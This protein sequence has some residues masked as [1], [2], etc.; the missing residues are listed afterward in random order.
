MN[1]L[2][3]SNLS[4]FDIAY[5]KNELEELI[6]PMISPSAANELMEISSKIFCFA[7]MIS[8]AVTPVGFTADRVI[9]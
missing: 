5:N 6:L 7:G 8:P 9:L 4:T 2:Q 3:I 1:N